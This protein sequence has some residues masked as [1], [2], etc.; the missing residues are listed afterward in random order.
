MKYK[1][2]SIIKIKKRT[3]LQLLN[4]NRLSGKSFCAQKQ[5]LDWSAKF[6]LQMLDWSAKFILRRPRLRMTLFLECAHPRLHL[7]LHIQP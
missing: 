2:K 5:M 3:T 6:I 4:V 1:G 7:G